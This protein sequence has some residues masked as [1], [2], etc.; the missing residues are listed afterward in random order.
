MVLNY[1]ALLAFFPSV[2]SSFFTQNSG[3]GGGQAPRAPLLD[4]PLIYY[5][6]TLV[7]AEKKRV[8]LLQYLKTVCIPSSGFAFLLSLS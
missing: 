6:D 4:P 2:I 7:W 5:D 1:L 8:T 3:G